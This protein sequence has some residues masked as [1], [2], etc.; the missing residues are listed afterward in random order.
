MPAWFAGQTRGA[1][2]RIVFVFFTIL[3]QVNTLTL[4]TR[5]E[6]KLPVNRQFRQVFS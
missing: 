1:R 2:T 3:Y 5:I 6:H 4:D